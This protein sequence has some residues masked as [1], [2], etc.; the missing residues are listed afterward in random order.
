M[1][2]YFRGIV[3]SVVRTVIF[4]EDT[5]DQGDRTYT[6]GN[7]LIWTMTEPGCYLICACMLCMRPLIRTISQD[8]MCIFAPDR[9][10]R[11][12]PLIQASWW[13]SVNE[14]KKRPNDTDLPY[15]ELR[16]ESCRELQDTPPAYPSTS[17]KVDTWKPLPEI[18][19]LP[20]LS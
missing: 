12:S 1:L 9:S 19:L 18:D 8:R 6:H 16:V 11:Q 13:R 7:L 15:T 5:Y 20:K 4:F 14:D 10:K 17:P 3:I 2:T